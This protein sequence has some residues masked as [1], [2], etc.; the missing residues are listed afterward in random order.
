MQAIVIGMR[1]C[2]ENRLVQE[3]G[4]KLV[5]DTCL[6]LESFAEVGALQNTLKPSSSN[7]V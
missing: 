6:A 3:R 5:A 4:L 1:E 7:N 2:G